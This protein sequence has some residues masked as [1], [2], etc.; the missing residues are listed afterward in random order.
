M[1][2]AEHGHLLQSILDQLVSGGSI[3]VQLVSG[4]SPGR[5][6]GSKR[7]WHHAQRHS[8]PSPCDCPQA[9][10]GQ[11]LANPYGK[12]TQASQ[13]LPWLW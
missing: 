13:G 1:Q 9:V 7:L 10:Q 12:G 11:A 5:G 3:L 4:G 8:A 2:Q 6:A